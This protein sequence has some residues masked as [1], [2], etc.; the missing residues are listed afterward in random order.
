[1][2]ESLFNKVA[3]LRPVSL[4][5]GD[6]SQGR[7]VRGGVEKYTEDGRLNATLVGNDT[8]RR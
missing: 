6:S 8:R 7:S 2:L 3:N 4:L 5:K 1:M